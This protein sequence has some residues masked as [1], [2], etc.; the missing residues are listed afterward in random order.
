MLYIV[1]L[2]M[3]KPFKNRD[4][5]NRYHGFVNALKEEYPN[6]LKTKEAYQA[7]CDYLLGSYAA[8]KVLWAACAGILG[9]ILFNLYCYYLEGVVGFLILIWML[10]S[11]GLLFCGW[12][13]LVSGMMSKGSIKQF[14]K[15]Y[16]DDLGFNDI[17]VGSGTVWFLLHVFKYALFG[18]LCL[19]LVVFMGYI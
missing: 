18:F 12:I 17:D 3:T 13:F 5:E 19:I 7:L 1:E 10:P 9:P 16:A 15:R 4:K 11:A 14:L 2:P 6:D 8:N